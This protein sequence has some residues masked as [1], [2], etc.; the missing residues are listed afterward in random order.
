MAFGVLKK[1]ARNVVP[2]AVSMSE[3]AAFLQ[4]STGQAVL[5]AERQLL[6]SLLPSLAG[7]QLLQLSVQRGHSVCEVPHIGR[8]IQMGYGPD[9]QA[10]ERDHIWGDFQEFPIASECID[11]VL[12]HHV[13]EFSND[14]HQL[15]READRTIVAGGHILIVGF[16]PWS[17]WPAYKR[18]ARWRHD[19]PMREKEIAS[20]RIAEWLSL[21]N[22]DLLR[23][24]YGPM[25]FAKMR[26]SFVVTPPRR[27]TS[28]GKPLGMFYVALARKRRHAR[29]PTAM[30]WR[31]PR[32]RVTAKH[33][34]ARS[35]RGPST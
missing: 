30:Q 27:E 32:V 31:K 13:L 10:E 20:W 29:R 19:W 33:S 11:I 21:L 8:Y 25:R 35:H 12:L 26:Q 4:S 15:L 3:F 1:K 24:D 9:L 18:F 7:F 16:N 23:M 14:P 17:G 2:M 22:Y 34:A 6:E 28:V 5:S